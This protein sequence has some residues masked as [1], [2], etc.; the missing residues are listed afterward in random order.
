MQASM[1]Y[2][3]PEIYVQRRLT[4]FVNDELDHI[5]GLTY[6]YK[7]IAHPPPTIIAATDNTKNADEGNHTNNDSNIDNNVN[8]V[9]KQLH[10]MRFSEFTNK[11][12]EAKK[13]TINTKNISTTA[14]SC[15]SNDTSNNNNS[16]TSASSHNNS[17]SSSN[18][19]STNNSDDVMN[20]S[21]NSS[22]D[23]MLVAIGPDGGWQ[24]DEVL[25]FHRK[26]FQ[27]IHLGE[28]ILRTDIAVSNDII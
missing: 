15:F 22:K 28:R 12:I 1:D 11:I 7:I 9:E 25:L 27:L 21:N 6:A 19:N 8:Y 4:R 26:G 14:A 24:D 16:D 3:I 18:D 10:S 2:H 17:N 23:R 13:S 5:D 20:S